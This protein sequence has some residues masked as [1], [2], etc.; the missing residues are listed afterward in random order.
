MGSATSELPSQRTPLADAAETGLKIV[1]V[2]GFGVGKTTLV[3]SVSEIRPLN[4]EEVMTQAGVGVDDTSEVAGKTTTTVAFDFG[5]IS[6][7]ERMVLYLFGAPGQERFWFLWDR[8]FSGTLGAV[9]LVDTRRMD[10]SWYAIDRLE[11][12]KLP[13]VV[14]V[15]RFDD[16]TTRYSLDEIRQ[17]L[18]LP[19]H[20][21]LIDCD[22]RV[23]QSGKD[24]L[25]TLVDHLYALATAQETT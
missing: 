12:H 24:V 5:R 11:H 7:N 14:A 22:A 3:R 8:L 16:E 1:I 4:T 2:G 25:I 10:E 18:A 6:L 21:P 17:S 20:V 15:N 23:R 9:V 13:F 19:E